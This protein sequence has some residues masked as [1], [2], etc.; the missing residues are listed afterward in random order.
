MGNTESEEELTFICTY[1]GKTFDR[2]DYQRADKKY[3]TKCFREFL[4]KSGAITL[5]QY[6]GINELHMPLSAFDDRNL[7]E[8][9]HDAIEETEKWVNDT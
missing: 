6:I 9:V 7:T 8:R 1:C 2:G 4:W 3:C 5:N